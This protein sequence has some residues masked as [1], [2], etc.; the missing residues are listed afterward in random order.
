[1]ELSYQEITQRLIS[2]ME[3]TNTTDEQL[4]QRTGIDAAAFDSMKKGEQDYTVTFLY[5]CAKL[6]NVDLIELLTGEAPR[7]QKYAVVRS[8][9]GLPMARRKDFKYQHLAH[10]FRNKLMEPF[11]VEAPWYEELEGM[12]IRLGHHAGQEMEFVLEGAL[13]IEIEGV[14]HI[15]H[16]GDTI[17]FDATSPHGMVAADGAPCKFLAIMARSH[18]DAPNA[19]DIAAQ[20]NIDVFHENCYSI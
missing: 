17:Y 9:E 4:C 16:A 3:D 10:L 19:P 13:R 20:N 12:P 7:L 6:F 14:Q 11:L 5:K 2:L 8:G 15:L 1:M 18:E